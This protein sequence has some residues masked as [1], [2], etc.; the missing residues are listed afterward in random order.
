MCFARVG[1]FG[2]FIVLGGV[3]V[4]FRFLDH[5][6]QFLGFKVILAIF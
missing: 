2:H 5:F 3:L 4:I 6:D 1:Y